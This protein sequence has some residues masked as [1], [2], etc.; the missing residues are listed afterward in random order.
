M[1]EFYWAMYAMLCVWRGLG[2]VE[3]REQA[4]I[5]LLLLWESHSP[6]FCVQ[7]QKL[8]E[9]CPFRFFWKFHYIYM[10]D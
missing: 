9:P 6:N 7:K 5:L 1:K 4:A 10:F 2:D 8:P 3:G